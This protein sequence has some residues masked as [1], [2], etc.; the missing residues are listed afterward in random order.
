MTPLVFNDDLSR[1]VQINM[2]GSVGQ[3]GKNITTDVT[4]VQSMLNSL[5]APQGGPGTRLAVDGRI[6]PKTIAAITSVQRATKRRVVDGRIDANGPTIIALGQLLNA[7][8]LMPR[9][10]QGIGQPDERVRR[11]LLPGAGVPPARRAS[12]LTGSIPGISPTDWKFASSSGV[13]VGA[14]I[15]GVAAM[16]FFLEQDSRPG[17]IRQFPWAGVGVGLSTMPVGLDISFG[18]FPSFGLRLRQGLFGSN[19]LP[20]LDLS[21]P[22]TVYSFGA[23]VGPGISITICMFGALGPLIFT[24]RAVGAIAGMEVGIPGAGIMGFFGVTDSPVN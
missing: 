15:F 1:L 21:G 13:T 7:R 16:R 24:S 4:I 22:C 6:G 10:V 9:G 18:D 3:G 8:G 20:V 14:S 17:I 12:G 23:S 11:G 19:P 2:Q 5:P